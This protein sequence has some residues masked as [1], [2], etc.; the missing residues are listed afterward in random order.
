MTEGVFFLVDVLQN[1]GKQEKKNIHKEPFVT[2]V[3]MCNACVHALHMF[4]EQIPIS[5]A[6][7]G[8]VALTLLQF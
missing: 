2:H 8:R 3:H 7:A 4:D 1:T 5:V 6:W